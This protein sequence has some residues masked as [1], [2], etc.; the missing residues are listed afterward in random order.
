MPARCTGLELCMLLTTPCNP[1]A[2]IKMT[3][4]KPAAANHLF[5]M[6]P[7]NRNYAEESTVCLAAVKRRITHV[8]VERVHTR[9]LGW[10]G[11][12]FDS[13]VERQIRIHVRR[14][15][16]YDRTIRSTERTHESCVANFVS[17]C[18]QVEHPRVEPRIQAGHS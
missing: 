6:T 16:Q 17:S 10:S 11:Q 3:N 7:P 1:I 9:P 13:V 8:C 2:P 4:A 18:L 15:Q 12:H 5:T 14:G